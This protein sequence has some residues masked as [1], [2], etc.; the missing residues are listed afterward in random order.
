M[1]LISFIFME[2]KYLMEQILWLGFH[3]IINSTTSERCTKTEKL[4]IGYIKSRKDKKSRFHS[5]ILSEMENTE[6]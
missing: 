1:N 3:I 6:Y 2:N 4:E 5:C